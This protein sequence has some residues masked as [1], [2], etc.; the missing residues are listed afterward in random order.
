MIAEY[1]D[2][3]V[4]VALKPPSTSVKTKTVVA[5]SLLPDFRLNT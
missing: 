4:A 1:I 2:V 3:I 5:S